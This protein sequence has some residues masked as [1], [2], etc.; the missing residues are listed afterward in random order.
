MQSH[1]CS[2]PMRT[3]PPVAPASVLSVGASVLSVG[4]SVDSVDATVVSVPPAED[5]VEAP[6]VSVDAAVVGVAAADVAVELLVFL[7]SLPHAAAT[8]VKPIARA[9]KVFRLFML[10]CMCLL[11]VSGGKEIHR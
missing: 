1:S 9:A 10:T 4:A 11:M 2:T 7:S 3:V 5:S 6:V 8:R